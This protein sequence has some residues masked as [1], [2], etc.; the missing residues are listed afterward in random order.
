M[1]NSNDADADADAEACTP[2]ATPDA[3]QFTLQHDY[4]AFDADD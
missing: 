4:V 2:G 3:H 1:Q